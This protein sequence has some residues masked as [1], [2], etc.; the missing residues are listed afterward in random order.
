M[1]IIM[2]M[3]LALAAAG[4]LAAQDTPNIVVEQRFGVKAGTA[5]I[6]TMEF[7]AGE[8]A[9]GSPV[10]NAPYSAQ[11]V[12][13]TTQTLVDGNR[14]VRNSSSMIYRDSEG[15]ERRELSLGNLGNNG[16]PVQTVFISDPVAG[17]NL[18]LD[19][20]TRTAMKMP[21]PPPFSKAL[22]RPPAG[23]VLMPPPMGVAG[24]MI[25]TVIG[26]P[27]L[28]IYRANSDANP[29]ENPAPK[30]EQ[31]GTKSI[32]GLLAEGTRTTVTI[33]PGQV[34]NEQPIQIVSERW[35]SPELK[36]TVLSTH[37]DPRMGDTEYRMTN[38]SRAEP[39]PSLFQ[40]PSDY[41]LKDSPT[42]LYRVDKKPEQP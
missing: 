8:L 12:T 18:T 10:K 31:L 15:R 3:T 1:K 36:V 23:D 37:S 17:T 9:G 38:L 13:Q 11:A 39:L 27:Q 33:P 14:I 4:A 16:E 26:A 41:T 6:S 25:P 29:G 34:G 30:M 35:Y 24:G 2:N 28:M 22:P 7:V 21:A 40:A 42:F 32:E 5:G 19:T 20:K